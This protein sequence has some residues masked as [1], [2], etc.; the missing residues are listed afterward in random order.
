MENNNSFTP[1]KITTALAQ[2]NVTETVIAKLKEYK[3]LTII[4]LDDQEGYAK[5]VTARKECKRI[6]N[7]AEKICKRGR[8]DAI[9]EQKEWVAKE[10]EITGQIQDVETCL[11]DREVWFEM[12]VEKKQI[13][14][15][16]LF[17]LPNRKARMK[18]FGLA[19]PDDDEVLLGM[20]DIQFGEYVNNERAK[21]LSYQESRMKANQLDEVAF[22]SQNKAKMTAEEIQNF[23]DKMTNYLKNNVTHEVVQTEHGPAVFMAS[24]G[25][26]AVMSDRDLLAA[27]AESMYNI[28]TPT[29][30]G[31]EAK[32]ILADAKSKFF[33]IAVEIVKQAVLITT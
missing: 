8:E 27:F 18:E 2:E 28:Q 15:Q 30:I 17:I 16:R 20:D 6:R 22:L 24:N 23:G 12:E 9:K 29:V 25:P 26:Y 19:I 7:L 13:R 10:K 11:A 31:E 4:D 5:I 33:K 14:A 21:L 32:K 3:K 1:A